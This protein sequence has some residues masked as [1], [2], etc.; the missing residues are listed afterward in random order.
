MRVRFSSIY[1]FEGLSLMALMLAALFSH[2]RYLEYAFANVFL[3]VLL[4]AFSF[5]I[6]ARGDVQTYA[7]GFAAAG[8]VYR[9]LA[10]FFATLNPRSFTAPLFSEMLIELFDNLWFRVNPNA[11]RGLQG[12]LGHT[13][14]ALLF[15]FFGGHVTL[16]ISDRLSGRSSTAGK[17]Q[18][19]ADGMAEATA[20][21]DAICRV[22]GVSVEQL[23]VVIVDHGSRRAESNDSLLDVTR[24]FRT[25]TG[26]C[27]VEPAHMELAQ[28]SI[29]T[30]FDRAVERGARVVVVHPY[31]LSPGRHWDE[32]IPALAAAAAERH[33]DVRY[34]VTAPLG[35]HELM[36]QIM[37]DRIQHCLRYAAGNAPACDVC[38]DGNGNGRCRLL[39]K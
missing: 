36:P 11:L 30:A 17:T 29:Q 9:L 16:F 25:K 6:G 31:F 27:I 7:A 14:W 8:T 20:N 37:N 34:L 18:S 26:Y 2:S 15:A 12:H 10:L 28:P 1:V 33:P 4:A 32:D 23:G 3:F 13:L 38:E 24:M 5:A 35:I 22:L 19:I 39:P 21:M